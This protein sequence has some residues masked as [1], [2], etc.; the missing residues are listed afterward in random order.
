MDS[1]F[2]EFV[3]GQSGRLL[4][5]A[6]LLT[7]DRGHAEDLV[8]EVLERVYVKWRSIR[9][10]PAAYAR[11][12]LVHAATNRWRA[13]GRR[14]E[15]PLPERDYLGSPDHAETYATQ[16]AVVR[17]LATLPA[18]QR[19]VLVLRYLDDLSEQDTAAVLGC[20][21]GTVKSQASRGLA[22]LRELLSLPENDFTGA[23]NEC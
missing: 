12:A 9:T 7:G 13:R 14:P 19:A 20:S 3:Q 2:A 16:D 5:T 21:A 1:D 6:F 22:R 10:S 8:Q 15:A 18:R 17:A 11:R 23:R 4:R